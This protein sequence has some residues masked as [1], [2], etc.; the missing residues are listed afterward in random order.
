MTDCD[1]TDHSNSV[2]ATA[3]FAEAIV[4]LQACVQRL[5]RQICMHDCEVDVG[6]R[7][8]AIIVGYTSCKPGKNELN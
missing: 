6:P 8:K 2:R 3:V 4:S 1:R 7:G 5:K